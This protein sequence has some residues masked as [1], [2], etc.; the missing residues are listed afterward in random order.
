MAKLV[1]LV[2]STVWALGASAA[3][4]TIIDRTFEV[5]GTDFYLLYGDGS[6]PPLAD[7]LDIKFHIR[8]DNSSDTIQSTDNLT[9][10]SFNLPYDSTWS[11]SVINDVFTIGSFAYD[12]GC[13]QYDSTYCVSILHVSSFPYANGVEEH[14]STG[15]SWIAGS[16]SVGIFAQP[17]PV[18]ES[19]SWMMMVGGFATVGSALRRKAK[20]RFTYA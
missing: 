1:C 15:G 18:P 12:G 7:P 9:I 10:D 5:T 6:V 19:A 16:T 13:I 2:A 4:A 14:S 20:V 8:F 11:Y 17:A 3:S